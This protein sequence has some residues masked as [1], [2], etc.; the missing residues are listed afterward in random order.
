MHSKTSPTQLEGSRGPSSDPKIRDFHAGNRPLKSPPRVHCS[1]P[2]LNNVSLRCTLGS[3]VHSGA[4][5]RKSEATEEGHHIRRGP[6]KRCGD[7]P[8]PLPVHRGTAPNPH[9]LPQRSLQIHGNSRKH[10]KLSNR[11]KSSNSQH[12]QRR[13]AAPH[14]APPLAGLLLLVS[15]V[16]R[17]LDF[18]VLYV[19]TNVFGLPRIS[20]AGGG[21]V[22]RCT[23]GALARP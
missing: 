9:P 17:C 21:P 15:R 12:Q 7:S 14:R 20:G 13:C 1:Q 19:F 8:H 16:F 4:G 5:E 22:P 2:A 6:S 11:E 10:R 23:G 18:V 3:P